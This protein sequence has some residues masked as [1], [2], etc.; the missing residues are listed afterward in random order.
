MIIIV[1]NSLDCLTKALLLDNLLNGILFV[2]CETSLR[3]HLTPFLMGANC[4]FNKNI[5]SVSIYFIW[6]I[7]NHLNILTSILYNCR[8]FKKIVLDNPMFF[9]FSLNRETIFICWNR[10]VQRYFY[11]IYLTKNVFNTNE[12]VLCYSNSSHKIIND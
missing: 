7:V 2:R 1:R 8:L 4:I 11:N 3:L 12:Y 10:N 6:V 5:L 9:V